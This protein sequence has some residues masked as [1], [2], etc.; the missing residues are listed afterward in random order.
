MAR[1][2]LIDGPVPD[3]FCPMRNV[4]LIVILRDQKET[5]PVPEKHCYALPPKYTENQKV[6]NLIS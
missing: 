6:V 4:V 5:P 2:S 3:L 1:G